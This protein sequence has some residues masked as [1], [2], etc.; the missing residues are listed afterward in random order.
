MADQS[1]DLGIEMGAF[2]R[3]HHDV[4]RKGVQ[5]SKVLVRCVSLFPH[6]SRDRN[7]V[8]EP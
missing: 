2:L 4:T 3:L 1:A 8:E 7:V 6:V 5:E